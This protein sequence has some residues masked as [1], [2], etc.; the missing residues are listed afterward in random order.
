LFCCGSVSLIFNLRSVVKAFPFLHLSAEIILLTLSIHSPS[1]LAGL[2]KW[3]PTLETFSQM[4]LRVASAFTYHYHSRY[5]H[6]TSLSH[7][8]QSQV[9]IRFQCVRQNMLCTAKSREPK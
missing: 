9:T 2:S 4:R 8:H 3:A 7:H 6:Q 1:F 5:V